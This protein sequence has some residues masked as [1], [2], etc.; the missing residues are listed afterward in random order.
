[1]QLVSEGSSW[2][3]VRGGHSLGRQPLGDLTWIKPQKVTPFDEGNPSF[4]ASDGDR[5][6]AT[7]TARASLASF[8]F[9]RPE[10]NNRT[11][12]DNVAGT[13]TTHSPRA[14]SCWASK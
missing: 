9:E 7:A 1:V 8:L 11:R 3:S 10:P 13:S 6:A 5:N 14:I 4:S 2:R 12:D